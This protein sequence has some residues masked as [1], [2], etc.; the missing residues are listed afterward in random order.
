VYCHVA[1]VTE[2]QQPLTSDWRQAGT[3]ALTVLF[4]TLKSQNNV[5]DHTMETCLKM[6]IKMNLAVYTVLASL[7]KDAC[8]C[9]K[10]KLQK[11]T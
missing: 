9:L 3:L 8:L 1:G 2:L 11:N 4:G 7:Y 6:A 5:T 10:L